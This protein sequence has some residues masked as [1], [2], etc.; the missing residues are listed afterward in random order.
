VLERNGTIIKYIGDSIMAVWGAPIA[1]AQQA[2]RAVLAAWEMVQAG[3]QEIIGHRLRTRVGIHS[4]PALAGNLG[5]DVRFDYTVIGDTTNCASRLES[6][7]KY[8]KTEILISEATR[9]QLSEK[10]RTR[11]LGS[12]RLAGRAE[13]FEIHEVLGPAD[14]L[15]DGAP[16][17]LQF[18]EAVSCYC[19]RDLPGAE[20]LFLEVIQSRGGSDGPSEMYLDQIEATRK[21]APT[22][23]TWSGIIEMRSK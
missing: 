23:E 22:V 14:R 18:K 9:R 8:F 11:R 3:R 4:G 2:E 21:A 12:F 6:A 7:N 15:A 19:S 13:P 1:D 10:I 16:W 17:V 20:K 5:S